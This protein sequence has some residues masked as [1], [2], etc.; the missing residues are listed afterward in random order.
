MSIVEAEALYKPYDQ[1]ILFGDSI[2]QMS[3]DPQLEFG[4]YGALQDAYIRCLDVINRGFSGYTSGHAVNV[5]P[6]FFPTPERANVRFMTIFFGANDACLPGSA[7]HVPLHVFKEN[8]TR[9]IQHPVTVAQN[10]HILILTPP[11]VNEYQLQG[12]DESKGN[13]H[14]S[15]TAEHTKKYA[16]AV[17]E[18]GSSLGVPVVDVWSAFMS[19]T[20]W[21][22]G[23][24]LPGSRDLPSLEKFERFFTDGLHLTADGYR[25]VYDAIMET[26]QVNWPEQGPERLP[27]VFP[28]WTEA[29]R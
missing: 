11:P 16:E 19:A 5:F 2:T 20:G 4:L 8:L 27:S 9:I 17:R 22:E 15:R 21:K 3:S 12:F 6:K 25:V 24:P 29:P 10:P 1:F 18:V 26:I 7:Q 14:P 28:P 23:E 13:A